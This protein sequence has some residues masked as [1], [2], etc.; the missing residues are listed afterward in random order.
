MNFTAGRLT[1]AA[2]ATLLLN[3]V[4]AIAAAETEQDGDDIAVTVEVTERTTPGALA[5]TVAARSTSLTETGTDASTR[6]FTGAL[7]EVTVTDTRTAQ[8]IPDG[9]YWYVLGSVT[10]FTSETGTIGAQNLG[11]APTLVDGGSSGLVAE[12]DA[13]DP[14]LDGGPGLVDQELLAMALDSSTVADEGSWTASADLTLKTSP[15]VEAG[16]YSATLTLSLFE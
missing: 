7:P 8:E 9:A 13:V 15:T 14:E 11:W 5:M 2:T 12:G 10:D 4:T 16:S 1:A 3:G 6:V